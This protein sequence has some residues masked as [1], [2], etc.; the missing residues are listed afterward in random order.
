MQAGQSR[1]R[2][3]FFEHACLADTVTVPAAFS[4]SNFFNRLQRHPR[5][6]FIDKTI[7]GQYLCAPCQRLRVWAI[8]IFNR[9][10]SGSIPR[11][12]NEP[13]LGKHL[14][15]SKGNRCGTFSQH[16]NTQDLE[17]EYIK[18]CSLCTLIWH[19]LCNVEPG[20]STTDILCEQRQIL[21]DMMRGGQ[22]SVKLVASE[23]MGSINREVNLSPLMVYSNGDVV[24]GRGHSDLTVSTTASPTAG[25][26]GQTERRTSNVRGFRGRSV[27]A[28]SISTDSLALV[29]HT[30][31]LVN[32]CEARHEQ[33][34][35]PESST[36][37]TRLLKIDKGGKAKLTSTSRLH[38]N[39]RYTA[40]SCCWGAST[41][42]MAIQLRNSSLKSL[43]DGCAIETLPRTIR[44]A[45][46]F[47][48]RIGLRYIW[49]DSLCI[50]QDSDVDKAREIEAMCDI[51][52]GSYLTICALAAESMDGGLYSQRNPLLYGSLP[53]GKTIDGEAAV[54]RSH[55]SGSWW[56]W[57]S[58]KRGW[59]FQERVLSR[60]MM[61]FGPYLTWS[62]RESTVSEFDIGSSH[63]NERFGIG[64][65]LYQSLMQPN[66]VGSEGE[67]AMHVYQTWHEVLRHFH[68]T[69]LGVKSDRLAAI[70]GVISLVKRRTGWNNVAG[71]WEQFLIPELL[72]KPKT[73]S[74]KH[75][76]LAPSWSWVSVEGV[77]Y[78]HIENLDVPSF[79]KDDC[80][81]SVQQVQ[82]IAVPASPHSQDGMLHPCIRLECVPL[83]ILS[84]RRW[85]N[86]LVADLQDWPPQ[87]SVLYK[88]DGEEMDRVPEYFLPFIW[89]GIF[90][91]GLAVSISRKF[92]GMHERVG[93]IKAVTTSGPG[94]GGTFWSEE[95]SEMERAK[96]FDAARR[97]TFVLV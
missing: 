62:C 3:G 97:Q 63:S 17:N 25:L 57:P 49:V 20:S 6:V 39:T 70:T 30:V 31:R 43:V 56:Y 82:D 15:D 41:Q 50:I 66:V 53:L 12:D 29:E 21:E 24:R 10:I 37:P 13:D 2:N 72:W 85:K 28:H 38:Y 9:V 67:S 87:S 19:S 52:Q 96:L 77:I 27:M 23:H 68:N 47:T 45:I 1:P 59:I 5:G 36:L 94:S 11:G 76:G 26:F 40:L 61:N 75:T 69:A 78:P 71:L 89:R 95:I 90:I 88:P 8:D 91:I 80:L 79:N 54:I 60:R 16:E 42:S 51:Y 83:K 65:Q 81:I 92:P 48:Q 46:H 33:C 18:G 4:P 73:R 44:E 14:T 7:D 93:Y 64:A 22:G 35:K 58:H 55:A 32:E 84:L 74:A 86:K 34:K